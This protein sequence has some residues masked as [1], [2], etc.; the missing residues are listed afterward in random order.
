M[1][2]YRGKS[3]NNKRLKTT[4]RIKKCSTVLK[5]IMYEHQL[6]FVTTYV[7]MKYKNIIVAVQFAFLKMYT[8]DVRI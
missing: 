8:L 1:V 7:V 3:Q 4:Y 2:G 5:P 6:Q